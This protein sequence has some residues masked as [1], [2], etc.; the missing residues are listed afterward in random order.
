MA[1]RSLAS[2]DRGGSLGQQVGLAPNG[3]RGA[4]ADG[5]A[6]L[7]EDACNV[8]RHRRRRGA[9]VPDLVEGEPDQ[10]VEAGH[11]Y[12]EPGSAVAVGKRARRVSRD[13]DSD[14]DLEQAVKGIDRGRRIVDA[15]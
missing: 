7:A 6:E 3:R 8:E 12:V 15:G 2:G 1:A 14:Q 4:T 5:I 11:R 9:V 10:L 13:A